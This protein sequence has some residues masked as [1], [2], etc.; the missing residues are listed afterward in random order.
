MRYAVRSDLGLVRAGNEDRAY[1][2]AR[3]LALADG[4][5][6]HV[7][8]A[9]AAGL[10]I[11]ALAAVD[12]ETIRDHPVDL[13]DA[14]VQAANSAIADRVL[15]QPDLAGMG[16]TLTAILFGERVFGLAHIGDSRA[17]LLRDG[18]FTQLTHDESFV[19][20]L[21]DSG[22]ITAAQAATH[23][24]RSVILRALSGDDIEP[25]LLTLRACPGDRFLL[26]SDGLSDMVQDPAIADALGR[27]TPDDAADT[28]IDLA[29]TGGGRDNVTV[30]VADLTALG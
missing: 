1:A 5:G 3:L 23:P 24:Q 18:E 9:V 8:G 7:G 28:L 4:M 12:A 27:D 14:A 13:L 15:R 21:V 22:Q 25:T 2:G 26:C 20:T 16:T 30:I 29:L 6:G 11:D 17:Y 19:Q 10:A